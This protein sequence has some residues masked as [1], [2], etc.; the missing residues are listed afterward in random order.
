M[1]SAKM[2]TFTSCFNPHLLISHSR[3]LPYLL[4]EI[5]HKK[6][7]IS[8]KPEVVWQNAWTST[9]HRSFIF[10]C[11]WEIYKDNYNSAR[12]GL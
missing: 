6:P 2:F 10:D 12:A 5:I 4:T 1:P 8:Y 7:Y 9:G 3:L 11:L